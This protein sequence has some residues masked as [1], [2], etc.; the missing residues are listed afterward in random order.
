MNKL[1]ITNEEFYCNAMLCLATFK[2]Q[3]KKDEAFKMLDELTLRINSSKTFSLST[4]KDYMLNINNAKKEI[5]FN[6]GE[7]EECLTYL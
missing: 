6:R 5:C 2:D 4:K 7:K 1:N 3:R